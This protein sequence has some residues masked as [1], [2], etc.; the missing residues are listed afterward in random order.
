[1]PC[2]GLQQVA[3]SA[4]VEE[5]LLKGLRDVVVLVTTCN[6]ASTRAQLVR[7]RG[8]FYRALSLGANI[9]RTRYSREAQRSWAE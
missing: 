8:G 7:E 4:G 5:A 3:H 9:E 1:M 2:H 6:Q